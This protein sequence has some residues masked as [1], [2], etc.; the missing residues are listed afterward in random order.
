MS[1][2]KLVSLQDLEIILIKC[3]GAEYRAM[4]TAITEMGIKNLNPSY[5]RHR[6]K[7]PAKINITLPE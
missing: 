5:K 1:I 6:T 2:D 3:L 7:I 4:L